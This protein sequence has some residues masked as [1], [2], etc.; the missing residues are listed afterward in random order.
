MKVLVLR[1]RSEADW[2]LSRFYFDGIEK[3]VG[4]EDE[5]RDV[6][7][8]GETCIADDTYIMGLRDSPKFSHHF[9]RDDHGNIIEASMRVTEDN[10][11]KFHTPHEML[12]VMDVPLFEYI[13]W[14]WGNDDDDTDGCYCVG[15]IFGTISKQKGVLASKMKYK[16]IYPILWNAIKNGIVTVEYRTENQLA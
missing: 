3:G 9:Y 14:H 15:S 16:E 8:K 5:H 2:T 10:K 1:K 4:V 12:W 11:K 13:L 7:V 6:K